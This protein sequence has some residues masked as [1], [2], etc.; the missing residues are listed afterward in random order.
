MP[1]IPHSPVRPVARHEKAPQGHALLDVRPER[2]GDRRE[3]EQEQGRDHR[4]SH[5]QHP[6]G[7]QPA[8]GGRQ[9][10]RDRELDQP[11]GGIG[12]RQCPADGTD[13]SREEVGAR[14]QRARH[15]QP[16]ADAQPEHGVEDDEREAAWKQEG[17]GQPDREERDRRPAEASRRQEVRQP[18]PDQ[19]PH[20]VP[21][22]RAGEDCAHQQGRPVVLG[23]DVGCGRAP[24]EDQPKRELERK[25]GG[26]DPQ[27]SR[28]RSVAVAA[29][30][31]RAAKA[32]TTRASS[33]RAGDDRSDP[34][35]ITSRRP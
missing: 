7:R 10:G 16:A 20:P 31:I 6:Q 26:E 21:E 17:D 15:R 18:A 8:E 28:R 23:L 12:G 22:G 34:F 24:G 1:A 32:R 4:G 9:L 13:P 19:H 27:P 29:T 11:P 30:T 25:G 35:S 3:Q 2:S 14:R 33:S 5:T